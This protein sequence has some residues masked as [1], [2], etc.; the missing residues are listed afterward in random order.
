MVTPMTNQTELIR[1]AADALR[2]YHSGPATTSINTT[3]IN[4][5]NR[6]ARRRVTDAVDDALASGVMVA[7]I[8]LAAGLRQLLVTE[9][10]S[11]R[12]ARMEA[13]AYAA[14][15]AERYLRQVR[16][17]Q[18]LEAV[19]AFADDVPKTRIAERLGVTRPTVDN[20]LAQ[21]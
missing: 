4:A 13:L 12:P 14:H 17:A 18:R 5:A 21:S 2:A 19:R 11:S 7:Q 1:A 10:I 20:W 3:E 6:A 8:A 15:D 9:F 16:D